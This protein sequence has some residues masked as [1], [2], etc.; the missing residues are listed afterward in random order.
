MPF[1]VSHYSLHA[2]DVDHVAEAVALRDA[3]PANDRICIDTLNI[4]VNGD[5]ENGQAV[6]LNKS[7]WE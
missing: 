6:M 7:K 1:R 3:V 5:P 4:N 2:P